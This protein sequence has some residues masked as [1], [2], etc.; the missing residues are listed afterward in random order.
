MSATA[1]KGN[2]IIEYTGT[3]YNSYGCGA[4]DK[5]KITALCNN[6]VIFVPNTFSPNGDA[7]NDRFYLRGKG[8]YL[9]KSMRI[10][11]RLGQSVFQKLN[12][13]ADS[14]AEGWDGTIYGRKLPS[15]VYIYYI[16]VMCNN[17]V[18]MT[19]K[20]DITLLL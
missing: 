10:F 19:I 18:T 12:F 11:N 8:L 15:D 16:E 2:R 7:I 5:I 3:A 13:A 14:E 17:G 4:S 20:G 9:I 1:G 6:K